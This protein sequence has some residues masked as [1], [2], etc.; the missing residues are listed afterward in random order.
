MFSHELIEKQLS[1]V[2]ISDMSQDDLT[3]F[4]NY[5]Y[6]NLKHD[7]FLVNRLALIRAADK[8]DIFDLKEE[9]E[10]SLMEDIDVTNVLERLES[11]QLYKL[12][13][14]K[15]GCINY[16]VKFGKIFDVRGELDEYVRYADRELI[17]EM[18]H[19][20]LCAWRGF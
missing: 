3:T 18:L 6:S 19:E 2:Y 9:C 17:G 11:A 16:L 8:Y 7:E 12:G 20:I 13:N 10:V 1:T 14:L 5:L 15:D 4:L